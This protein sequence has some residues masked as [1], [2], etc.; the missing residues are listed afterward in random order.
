[1]NATR[2]EDILFQEDD[3][4]SQLC[5]A[6][7][8]WIRNQDPEQRVKKTIEKLEKNNHVASY[9]LEQILFFDV[10]I[11]TFYFQYNQHLNEHHKQTIINEVK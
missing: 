10:G 7:V 2:Y 8:D 1:M 5:K 3:F 6:V 4:E 11:P 9:I